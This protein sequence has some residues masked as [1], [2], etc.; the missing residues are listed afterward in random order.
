MPRL[1]YF[2]AGKLGTLGRACRDHLELE[3]V[4]LGTKEPAAAIEVL[5]AAGV[6]RIDRPI[7]W[8]RRHYKIT[9]DPAAI[10]FVAENKRVGRW[11]LG[12][13]AVAGAGIKASMVM[14]KSGRAATWPLL[15]TF[16]AVAG[17]IVISARLWAIR[18]NGRSRDD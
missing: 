1:L 10:H 17:I 12:L 8:Q 4:D 5:V 15:I 2:G 16:A 13:L 9:N 14:T 11:V 18:Q 7:A 6:E 3:G